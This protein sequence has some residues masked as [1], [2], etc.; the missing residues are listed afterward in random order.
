VAEVVL[1]HHA[2]GVTDGV[3]AFA[4]RLRASG[5]TVHTPDLF[6][7]VTFTDLDEAVAHADDLGSDELV[8]RATAA[9]D[10]LAEAVVYGGFSLGVIPAQ[11]LAQNRAGARAALLY[12]EGSSPTWFGAPW[13]DGV[14]LQVHVSEHDPWVELDAVRELVGG[15]RDAELFLYPGA[16]HLFTDGTTP[17]HDPAATEQVLRRSLRLLERRS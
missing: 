2:L 16:A 3:V 5:H 12:H 9:V 1:F 15:A 8:A 10:G 14:P 17:E 6:D 13:P 4:E 11:H 7:G